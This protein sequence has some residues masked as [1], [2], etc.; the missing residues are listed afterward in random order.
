M[1]SWSGSYCW[2]VWYACYLKTH[3]CILN[4]DRVLNI[5]YPTMSKS[6]KRL[7]DCL[8]IKE[9]GVVLIFFN[10]VLCES[11]L[12]LLPFLTV[13]LHESGTRQASLRPWLNNTTVYLTPLK[14]FIM[15]Q[16]SSTHCYYNFAFIL[17]WTCEY[18]EL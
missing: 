1:T 7:P 14:R 4:I 3:Q 5:V 12:I 6:P 18:S 10:G 2:L 13:A 15:E 9:P 17:V 8:K 16:C 11:P